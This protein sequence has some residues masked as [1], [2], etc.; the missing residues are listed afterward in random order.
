MEFTNYGEEYIE[1]L[2]DKYAHYDCLT[3]LSCRATIEW[4]GGEIKTMEEDYD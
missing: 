2:D 4:L 1:N 3:D